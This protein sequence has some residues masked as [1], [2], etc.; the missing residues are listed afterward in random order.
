[1]SNER[2]IMIAFILA[3]LELAFLLFVFLPF[4]LHMDHA[5]RA[6]FGCT[7]AEMARGVR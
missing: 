5:F 2:K 3:G 4:H 1:M 7:P 6:E